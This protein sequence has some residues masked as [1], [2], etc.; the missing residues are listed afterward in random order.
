MYN[1]SH[2]LPTLTWVI[3]GV[4]DYSGQIRVLVLLFVVVRL[5][6]RVAIYIATTLSLG[7]N[8]C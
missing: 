6:L 2:K 5:L 4:T 7:R 3:G 1:Q 8:Y